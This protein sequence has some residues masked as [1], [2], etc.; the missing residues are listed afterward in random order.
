MAREIAAIGAVFAGGGAAPTPPP[1]EALPPVVAVGG[2]AGSGA[3][4]SQAPAQDVVQLSSK[5]VAVPGPATGGQ[6]K[7]P[8]LQLP[9]SELRAAVSK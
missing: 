7:E 8:K 5:T 4:S 1:P 6:N 3:Q 9:P 2:A